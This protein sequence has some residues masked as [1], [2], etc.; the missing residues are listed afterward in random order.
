MTRT[1]AISR[2]RWISIGR[3]SERTGVR[4]ETI[5]YYERIGLLPEPP[6]S[7]GRHRLYDEPH[8]QRLVFIRRTRQLGFSLAEIRELLGLAKG[9]PLACSEV[10][11]LTEQHAAGIRRKIGDLK[12]LERVLNDLAAQCRGGKGPACPILDALGSTP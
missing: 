4:I 8:R 5:R 2:A 3:L 9:Y 1:I 6:R 11:A 7:A 10:K 12:T